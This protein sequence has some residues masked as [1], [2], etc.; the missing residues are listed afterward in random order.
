MTTLRPQLMTR[1][2][3]LGFGVQ[4]VGKSNAILTLARRCP[5]DTFWVLDNDYNSYMRLLETDFLEILNRPPTVSDVPTHPEVQAHVL[6]NVVVYDLD[7]DSWAPYSPIIGQVVRTQKRDD[8]LVLDS[9]TPTWDACQGWFTELVFDKGIDE[10]FMEVRIAKEKSKKKD[11]ALLGAFDG[12]VDWQV[13][14]KQYAAFYSVILKS[15]G[16]IYMTAETD[17]LA[18]EEGK[19]IKGVFGPHGV[20]PKGQKRLGHIPMTVLLMTKDR[21]GSWYMTTIKDRGR[22]EL[23]NQPVADFATD[24]FM[25]VAGWR[26]R[27]VEE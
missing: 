11:D 16:H 6:G 5:N 12:W 27:A 20:K 21:A 25:K 23:V 7:V 26:P 22:G 15:P 4:G 17:K 19:E 13:I 3:V 2:R 8:W 1:E 9:M 24:Y 14:N 10:Y 18:K